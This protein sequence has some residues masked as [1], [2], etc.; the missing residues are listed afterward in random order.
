MEIY[1]KDSVQLYPFPFYTY[2]GLLMTMMIT[3]KNI[4]HSRYIPAS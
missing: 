2:V 3:E 1:Y 4:N